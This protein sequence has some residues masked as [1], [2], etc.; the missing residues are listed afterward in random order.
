MIC[1]VRPC[2]VYHLALMKS[3]REVHKALQ[4]IRGLLGDTASVACSSAT[5]SAD[6]VAPPPPPPRPVP[7][8]APGL[9]GVPSALHA[10]LR[11]ALQQ[12][13][14]ALQVEVE[15]LR[16]LAQTAEDVPNC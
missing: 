7:T 5:S 13:L 10:D 11:G 4:D 3:P 9:P 1:Y 14:Q 15:Q 8:M 16:P 6:T 12:Q 2:Q